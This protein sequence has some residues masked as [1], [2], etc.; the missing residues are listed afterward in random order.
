MSKERTIRHKGLDLKFT[1]DVSELTEKIKEQYKPIIDNLKILLNKRDEYI[2]KMHNM[3][4]DTDVTIFMFTNGLRVAKKANKLYGYSEKQYMALSF[5][6]TTNMC[7]IEY[8]SR[9]LTGIGYPKILKPEIW[10]LV[11]DGSVIMLNQQYCAI[12]DKGKKVISS[13]YKAYRQDMDFYMKNKKPTR[14][15]S[16]RESKNKYTEEERERR[17]SFYKTMMRPFW[18]GGYKVIPKNKDLRV[19]YMLDWIEK[20]KADGL[21]VDDVYMRFVEKWSASNVFAKL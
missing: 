8:L 19:T 14:K 15:T 6:G 11:E 16:I 12:T 1:I 21:F 4:R 3:T 7:K 2:E 13:I 18:D 5:L 17:S 10:K 9:Y 20:R